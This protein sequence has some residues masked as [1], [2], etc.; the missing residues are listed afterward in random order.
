MQIAFLTLIVSLQIFFIFDVKAE[1]FKVERVSSIEAFEVPPECTKFAQKLKSCS[2]SECTVTRLIDSEKVTSKYQVLGRKE[3][4]CQVTI[5][6][7]LAN[8][9]T[10]SSSPFIC[11]F[12]K[13]QLFRLARSLSVTLSGKPLKIEYEN[14]LTKK[15]DDLYAMTGACRVRMNE[16]LFFD[17]QKMAIYWRQCKR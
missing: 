13:L 11:S 15:S 14:C 4:K 3:N 5:V 7:S 9:T 10:N 1:V 8:D 17:V 12:N 16:K 6:H 2:Q